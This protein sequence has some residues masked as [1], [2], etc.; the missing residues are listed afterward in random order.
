MSSEYHF[1]NLSCSDTNFSFGV[2]SFK[3][4]MYRCVTFPVPLDV[5]LLDVISMSLF[6]YEVTQWIQSQ[7]EQE[8][9]R[10]SPLRIPCHIFTPGIWIFP[11]KCSNINVIFQSSITFAISFI[12][13]G[14]ILYICIHFTT[15]ECKTLSKAF[16]SQFRLWTIVVLCN[17]QF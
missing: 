7:T 9:K 8:G 6:V 15:N 2:K 5:L 17:L 3:S 13:W 14:L 11:S 12:I 10:P 4:S 16:Y 1:T